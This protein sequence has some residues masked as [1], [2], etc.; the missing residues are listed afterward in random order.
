MRIVKS[1]KRPKIIKKQHK[2]LALSV[3]LFIEV[4]GPYSPKPGP[5]FP[6]VEAVIVSEVRMFWKLIV[7]P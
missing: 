1:S 3:K 6:N 4:P 7:T 2:S 5:T